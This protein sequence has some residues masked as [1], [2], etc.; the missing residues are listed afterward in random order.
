MF[1][2]RGEISQGT[3]EHE[4]QQDNPCRRIAQTD[5]GSDVLVT[6]WADEGEA[7]QE[8]VR[9]RVGEG[10]KAIVILLSGGIP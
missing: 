5:L 1:E 4:S 8:D 6:R 10:S 2:A 3:T 9:L 7:D